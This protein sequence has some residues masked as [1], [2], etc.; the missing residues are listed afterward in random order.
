MELY[1]Q[2]LINR[3]ISLKLDGKT[4]NQICLIIEKEVRLLYVETEVMCKVY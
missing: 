4:I 3:I 2:E 1:E